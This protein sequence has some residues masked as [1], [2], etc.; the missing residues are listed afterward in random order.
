LR[1]IKL[2]NNDWLYLPRV[3]GDATPDSDFEGV[4][5]PHSNKI[6]PWHSFDDDEYQ[7]IS[8]YR[9]RFALPEPL[10]GRRLF[11]DFDGAMLASTVAINGHTFEEYKG[12]FTPFSFDITDFV[13][14]DGE[15]VLTVSLDS[16]ERHDIAP[17][18]YVVDYMT[19]GGIYR[20][21]YLRYEEPVYVSNVFVRT[22]DV[23]T[24]PAIE[25]DI[26]LR[27]TL[28]TD[29]P[30]NVLWRVEPEE[31]FSE[32]HFQTGEIVV[33]AKGNLKLT[34]NLQYDSL[35]LIQLWTLE[36]PALYRFDAKL[37]SGDENKPYGDYF[38]VRF[39]FR[40]ARFREDG[41]YLN[42]QR[43]QLR[44]LNRHQNYPYIG[45][46]A[47]ERLQ[48]K[49]ADIIKHE[50]GC[51]I[52]RTSHY[53]QSPHFLSRCDEIG[54]LVFEEIPGWQ[55]IGDAEWQGLSLRY[56]REMIERDWN[57]PSIIMWGVRINES[58]DNTEFYLATN[59]LARELDPTRQTGGVRYFPHS[60]FLEDVFT[61]NDF[62]GPM[63]PIHS[64]WLITEFNGHMYPTK[65]FDG[66]E[67]RMEH[68]L[69]HARYHS[70]A[71]SIGG[72]AGAIGWCAFDYNT[73]AEFGSGDR[74]CYHGVSDIFRLPKWAA[75][76]YASQKDPSQG[77]V[78]K[79]ATLWT[80]GDRSE[81]GNNPVYIF[82][83]CDEIE[84]FVGEDHI[85]RCQPA[86]DEFPY[87]PHP[88]FKTTQLATRWGKAF[89]DLRIVGY[90]NGQAVAEQ[91]I[92]CDAQPDR[93]VLT[94]DDTELRADGADMTRLVF[95]VVD[96]FGNVLPYVTKSIQFELEGDAAE[97]VGENPFSLIGGQ[98]A[99]YVK[100]R[101]APGSVK[102]R[103]YAPRLDVAE[104]V[105][106]VK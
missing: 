33:P 46:A 7:F 28:D 52:V 100:A 32:S 20:D 22:Q 89:D 77:V 49:D 99:L 74:I 10:N 5:L 1:S 104:V 16:R 25:A 15:N 29:Q 55:H 64:P 44:G 75:W 27:N 90:I 43:L 91:M 102:I 37:Q 81:G 18:G 103:A 31:K 6:L 42:G 4:T 21:V 59:K 80:M 60:E 92:A 45:C 72:I 71:G 86:V 79:A 65:P 14:E 73:H 2:F 83:N 87:M 50:L 96:R 68:A 24:K 3:A 48:R 61:F 9:K 51:N 105:L 38:N 106:W 56:V 78:L 97:L 70:R 30:V 76:W 84:I 98:A 12:G 26:F 62:Y 34:V 19:F 69:R 66:E 47:P 11:I 23:L 94:V 36:D 93:L 40:E 88:P 67:R 53:P 101:H 95:A 35:S 8:T 57:H 82:S 39:G 58:M 63:E 17:Y 13:R 85:G 41:F 54:L